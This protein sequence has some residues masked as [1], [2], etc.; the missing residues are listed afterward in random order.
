MNKYSEKAE[1]LSDT[2][3]KVSASIAKLILSAPDFQKDWNIGARTN[4]LHQ[5]YK[6][7]EAQQVSLP[8]YAG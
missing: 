5:F 7:S 2:L 4:F 1:K 8:K 3:K 6:Q